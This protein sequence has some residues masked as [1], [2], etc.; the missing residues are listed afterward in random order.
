[1]SLLPMNRPSALALPLLFTACISV[2]PEYKEP[3]LE[4]PGV[5]TADLTALAGADAAEEELDLISW[6]SA[7]EDPVLTELIERATEQNFDLRAASARV[8][9]AEAVLGVERAKSGPSASLSAAYTRSGISE[10]TQFGLFP[11]QERE[12]NNHTAGL[13]ASW[14]IDFWGRTRRTIEA[15]DAE[16]ESRLDDY[17]AARVSLAAQVAD[18][19]LR[20]REM[21]RREWIARENIVALARSLETSDARFQAGLTEELDVFRARTELESARAVLPEAARGRASAATE[22]EILLGI[23][24]GTLDRLLGG[25]PNARP[26]VP[27]PNGQIATQVPTDLLRRRPDLRSAERQLAAQTAR[28]GIATAA[29]YPSFTLLGNIGFQ[30]EN[31]GNLLDDGSATHSFGPSIS[32]PFF[33]GGGLRANI[34]AADARVEQ[35]LV[36]YERTVLLALHEVDSAAAGIG[37][38]QTRLAA[39]ERARGEAES[40]L[41]RSTTLYSEGLISLDAVLDARRA[42]FGIE[43]SHAQARSAASRAHVDLYRALGGG[44]LGAGE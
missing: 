13:G 34:R 11:G 30:A 24:P 26:V 18:A 27:F 40:S 20:L 22:I 32:M 31:L 41:D 38:E 12:S 3:A 43:D 44:W 21:Q 5:H 1:M 6:W 14:E 4:L 19:Y 37:F 33:S 28:V 23:E 42:L 17:S 9:E 35:A 2:G 36:E 10:N 16:L 25:P 39:L 8:S 15:A 29:L 7:F